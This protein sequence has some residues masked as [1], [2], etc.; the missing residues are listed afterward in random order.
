MRISP[1]C[2]PG[3]GTPIS[4][5]LVNEPWEKTNGPAWMTA[6]FADAGYLW[7]SLKDPAV[8]KG[9]HGVLDREPRP[10]RT[11]LERSQQLPRTRRCD[12]ALRRRPGGLDSREHFEQTGNRNLDR[13]EGVAA[14]DGELHRSAVKIPDGF[15]MVK[16]LEFAPEHVTFV[17]T[18]G[19][20]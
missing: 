14:D 5:K 20:K 8:L 11:S 13:T 17:S 9:K 19:K 16:T 3:R 6:T 18:T 4:F 15:E 7:F 10:P 12:G 1:G 2:R